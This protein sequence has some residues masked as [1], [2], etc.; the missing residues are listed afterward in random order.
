VSMPMTDAPGWRRAA[1]ST[2]RPS[3][4]PRSTISGRAWTASRCSYPTSSSKSR[5]PTTLRMPLMIPAR[6]KR[7]GARRWL[8]GGVRPVVF[9]RWCSPG[10]GSPGRHRPADRASDGTIVQRHHSLGLAVGCSPSRGQA[11]G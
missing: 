5:R 10:G 9:A 6:Y 3:P 1:C 2:A 4:V 7:C 8:A 11:I